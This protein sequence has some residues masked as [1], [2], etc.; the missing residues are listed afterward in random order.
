MKVLI[1]DDEPMVLEGLAALLQLN[2]FDAV[3][4]ADCA[5]AESKLAAEF[6]PLILAD[7]RLRTEADG[8]RLIESVRRLSP[9]SRIASMTGYF[10]AATE[11]RLRERGAHVVLQKPLGEEELVAALREM[12]AIVE[13]TEPECSDDDELYASTLGVLHAI[14]RRR[15]GFGTQDVED[16][17]QETWL[18]FLEKRASVRAPR[19]WLTGAIANLC[20][21]RI[22]RVCRD[23]ARSAEMLDIGMYPRHDESL[24]V[25]QAM[26]RLDERSRELCTMLGLEERTYDEV[27]AR[28]E[29][30]IGSVGPLYM[31]AKTRLRKAISGA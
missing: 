10:D 15:F 13:Q 2:E 30:P 7:V 22:D 20:R 28:L 27:S 17:V 18:L 19:A 5:E 4:A 29:I 6:F 21:Q 3:A 26:G 25:R 8:L 12:L 14:A 23:R 24:A 16:L 1:V 9:R 31:R 11:Q